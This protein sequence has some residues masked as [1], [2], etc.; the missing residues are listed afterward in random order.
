MTIHHVEEEEAE[1]EGEGIILIDP[2][3][4]I[5]ETEALLEEEDLQEEEVVVETALSAGKLDILQENVPMKVMTHR[6][7]LL[8]EEEEEGE[9]IHLQEALIEDL[10]VDMIPEEEEGEEEE[11]EMMIFLKENLLREQNLPLIYGEEVNL[12]QAGDKK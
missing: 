1:E 3:E 4:E 7:A 8:L 5:E 11:E 2:E 9:A 10:E 12:H 6:D